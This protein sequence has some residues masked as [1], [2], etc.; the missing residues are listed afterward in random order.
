MKKDFLRPSPSVSKHVRKL[1]A[2]KEGG[3]KG[4]HQSDSTAWKGTTVHKMNNLSEINF[5]LVVFIHFFGRKPLEASG[6]NGKLWRRVNPC[7]LDSFPVHN[8]RLSL[9]NPTQPPTQRIS[10]APA[11]WAFQR[12]RGRPPWPQV[13]LQ[14]PLKGRARASEWPD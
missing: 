5:Y 14:Q 13:R 1:K 12:P 3:K 10:L 4:I 9:R 6:C 7:W 11:L 2:E 8:W